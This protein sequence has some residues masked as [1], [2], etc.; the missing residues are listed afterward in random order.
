MVLAS[1][2]QEPG[3]EDDVGSI[4]SGVKLQQGLH[5]ALGIGKDGKINY[6]VF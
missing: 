3:C 1:K 6:I 5:L 2:G 4:L